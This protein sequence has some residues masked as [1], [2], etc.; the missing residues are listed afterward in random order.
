MVN[1]GNGVFPHVAYFSNQFALRT[2]HGLARYAR[3]LYSSLQE[4][5]GIRVTPV[6]AWSNM[7]ESR[8]ERLQ[9]DTGLRLLL[10]GKKLTPL[11]WTFL[12]YPPIEQYL[13]G[14]KR[15]IVVHS[16]A[17]GYPIATRRPYIVTVHDV[18]PLILPHF[19]S[20]KPV[21]FMKQALDQMLRKADAI[22]CVSQSTADDLSFYT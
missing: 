9:R 21:W 4:E 11:L 1:S 2:G 15:D 10:T 5:S 7:E 12:R 6:A 18:G 22:V 8:L 16:V 19:F 20:S 17:L 3:E 13:P 14:S